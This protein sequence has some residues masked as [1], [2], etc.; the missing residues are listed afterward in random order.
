MFQRPD[1][2][3]KSPSV[4]SNRS[5]DLSVPMGLGGS[6]KTRRRSFLNYKSDKRRKEEL[7]RSPGKS[8]ASMDTDSTLQVIIYFHQ[9]GIE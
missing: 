8:D 6:T 4:E 2:S 3:C 9:I 1:M 5:S 7:G